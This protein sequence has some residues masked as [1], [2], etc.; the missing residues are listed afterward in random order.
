MLVPTSTTIKA[1]LGAFG[2][3]EKKGGEAAEATPEADVMVE[4]SE[5]RYT[6]VIYI[7]IHVYIYTYSYIYIYVHLYTCISMNK[8]AG[9]LLWSNGQRCDYE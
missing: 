9:G 5:V 3:V 8:C 6:Y 4:S 7:H 1:A 2:L